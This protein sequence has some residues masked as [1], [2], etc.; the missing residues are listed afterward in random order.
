MNEHFGNEDLSVEELGELVGMSLRQLQRKIKA[1]T[2]RLPN[3]YIR[4]YR[5]QRA[6]EMIRDQKMSVSEA[7]YASG[8]SNLSYFAK[9]FK[10]EFGE[11]PSNT[12]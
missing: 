10:D 11:L 5:L 3:G 6:K 7:A 1:V 9:C 4:Y 8:F 2:G 12:N